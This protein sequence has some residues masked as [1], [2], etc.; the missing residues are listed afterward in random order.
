MNRSFALV[1]ALGVSS[2]ALAGDLPRGTVVSIEGQGI[3]A[4]WHEGKI[5]VTSEGCTMVTLARPS[6]DGYTMIALIA[7]KRLQRQQSGTWAEVSVK[8]LLSHEPK[9][10]LTEGAD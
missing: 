1:A 9:P 5:T 10:C 6:K 8:T 3:E 2:A 4:G 7:T